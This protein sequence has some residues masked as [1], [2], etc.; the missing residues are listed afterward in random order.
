M[1][2]LMESISYTHWI[3]LGLVLLGLELLGTT[4]FL[5][6]IASSALVVG[7]VAWM[8]EGFGWQAQVTLFAVLSLVYSWVWFQ[9]FRKRGPSEE[10][11]LINNRAAQ[12]IGTVV[13]ASADVTDG[14]GKI[15]LGDTLWSVRSEMEIRQGDR[16]R[17]TAAEGME[18]LV[19]PV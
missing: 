1:F 8:F 16:I 18:L 13:E 5:L 9:Y 4:G 14:Q 11:S 10:T 2:E 19:E 17:V 6:G 7:L 15:A 12:L 3:T